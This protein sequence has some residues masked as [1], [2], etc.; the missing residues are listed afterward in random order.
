MR[1][2]MG[3]RDAWRGVD[4]KDIDRTVARAAENGVTP[5][6]QARADALASVPEDEREELGAKIDD[7]NSRY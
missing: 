5:R 4:S 2:T 7:L 3:F 1:T 6:E